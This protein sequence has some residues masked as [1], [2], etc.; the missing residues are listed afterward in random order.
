MTAN[1]VASRKQKGRKFQQEVV[2]AIMEMF[3]ELEDGDAI[4]TSMGA[5]GVDIKLSPKALKLLPLAIE[6]KAQES[7]NVWASYEQAKSNSKGKYIPVVIAK[8]NRTEPIVVLS[9]TN[10]LWLMS[11]VKYD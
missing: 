2:K 6:C 3:P 9:F 5:S 8:R 1:T 10:F 7:F 4:S 11:K